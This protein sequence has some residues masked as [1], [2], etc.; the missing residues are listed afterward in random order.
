MFL[1]QVGM[2]LV[3]RFELLLAH[4]ARWCLHRP[5]EANIDLFFT[6]YRSPTCIA[7]T[8]LSEYGDEFIDDTEEQ[9]NRRLVETG[10]NPFTDL[11]D[12][13][14]CPFGPLKSGKTVGVPPRRPVMAEF[15][16]EA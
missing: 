14:M 8:V 15:L 1:S 3:V 11:W 16:L 12:S 6:S 9:D 5:C 4:A 10:P 13:A 2:Q 7:H